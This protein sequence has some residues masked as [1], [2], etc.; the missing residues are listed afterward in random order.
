ML[1]WAPA[2]SMVAAFLPFMKTVE[3]R[4]DDSALPQVQVSPWRAAES[5]SKK[6]SGEPVAIELVPCPGNGQLEGSLLRAAGL[7]KMTSCQLDPDVLSN[8]TDCYDRCVPSGKKNEQIRF[9]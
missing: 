1:P 9:S 6:T 5:P 4:A 2:V 7:A 8:L 3:D